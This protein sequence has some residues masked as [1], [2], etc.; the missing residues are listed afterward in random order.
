MNNFE[1]KRQ[2]I[3]IR[4]SYNDEMTMPLVRESIDL[5][6]E[7]FCEIYASCGLE[8]Q[9]YLI[10]API[11]SSISKGSLITEIIIPIAQIVI[12]LAYD[13]IKTKIENSKKYNVEIM[14]TRN[15]WTEKDT[16]NICEI[17]IKT[18]VQRKKAISPRELAKTIK[19]SKNYGFISIE[20]K[21]KNTGELLQENGIASTL[22]QCLKNYSKMHKRIFLKVCKDFN[23]L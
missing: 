10:N 23:I 11:V 1:N 18:Y 7:A 21:I 12:P 17:V 2:K 6:D 5:L 8:R 16:K 20:D 3:K 22:K 19:L 13:I 15:T 14:K 4:I 9:E